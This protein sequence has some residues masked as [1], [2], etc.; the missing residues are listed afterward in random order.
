LRSFGIAL[1][2]GVG[3]LIAFTCNIIRTTFLTYEGATKGVEAT[4]KWHDTA[5]FVILGVV[6]V[7]LFFI[8]QFLDRRT[9]ARNVHR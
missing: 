8:S 3:V 1:L 2:A 6:L 7:C 9:A 4:E 5:G